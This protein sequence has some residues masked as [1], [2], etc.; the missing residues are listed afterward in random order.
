MAEEKSSFEEFTFSWQA[1]KLLGKSLYS[2]PWAAVSELV[3]NGF[4]AGANNVWVLLDV[5]QGNRNAVLEVIDDG[6]GMDA[7]SI[8]EYVQVGRNKRE[9]SDAVVVKKPMGRKGIGKLAALYLSDEYYLATKHGSEH[10]LWH[11]KVDDATEMDFHPRLTRSDEFFDPVDSENWNN[12]KSGTLLQMRDVDLR[13]IGEAAFTALGNRLANQ[14]LLTSMGS[15]NIWFCLRRQPTHPVEYKPVQKQVAFSNYMLAYLY[16]DDQTHTP[17]EL[18]MLA[19]KKVKL[20]VN[21]QEQELPIEVGSLE[22][23]NGEKAGEPIKGFLKWPEGNG[24]D[25]DV[26][27]VLEG[28]VAVHATIDSDL[29]QKNDARFKKNKFYHPAQIRLYVRGK[30][31]MEDVLPLLGITQAYSNYVE[32]EVSFDVLDLDELPDIATTNRQGFDENDPRLGKL[33]DILKPIVSSLVRKREKVINSIKEELEEKAQQVQENAR[34]QFLVEVESDLSRIEGLSSDEVSGLMVPIAGKLESAGARAKSK[35]GV[36]LS[37]S[38]MDRSFIDFLDQLLHELGAEDEEIFYT[39]RPLNDPV[40]E[41]LVALQDRIKESLV[42]TKTQI[43]YIGSPNFMGSEFCLFEGGAGWATRGM[44]EIDILARTY[45][46][47]P[48]FLK[49]GRDLKGLIDEKGLLRL[50]RDV[51]FT[52]GAEIN[53]LVDHLNAGRKIRGEQDSIESLKLDSIKP[54]QE[55]GDKDTLEDFLDQRFVKIWKTYVQENLWNGEE[56]D[57]K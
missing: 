44:S 15:Q 2:N 10:S 28:W 19:G 49:D 38:R 8:K 37:H 20:K 23:I 17:N 6:N 35:H 36:F 52:V 39:S 12:L 29:A 27:Y 42:D 40:E 56:K 32:G 25:V 14:F 18:E 55:W 26:D 50:T 5:S 31:A 54:Q 57:S 53:K 9:F 24:E 43:L 51:Y 46:D 1:L 21:D 13:G 45:D 47:I 48:S 33:L 34:T 41:N 7:K 30:L 11:L 22:R 16:Y 3:A 4:D